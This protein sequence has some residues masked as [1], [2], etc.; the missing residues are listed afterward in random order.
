[1][2]L[3]L[4]E[5]MANG[6]TFAALDD[7][8]LAARWRCA[9]TALRTRSVRG[10]RLVTGA[11]PPLGALGTKLGAAPPDPKYSAETAVGFGTAP[12]P[13]L[14]IHGDRD[15]TTT[16][17]MYAGASAFLSPGSKIEVIA[18]TGHFFHVEKLAAVN[19][20]IVDWVTGQP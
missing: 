18:G 19:R 7:G 14:F 9:S 8:P 11:V 4:T 13:T 2:K 1:M 15:G 3:R 10:R 17:E 5:V 16:A 20:L 12:Q 6:L